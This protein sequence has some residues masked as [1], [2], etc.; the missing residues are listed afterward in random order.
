MKK[1][2]CKKSFSVDSY[3]ADGFLIPNNEK[4]V[5]EG[6]VYELDESERTII[7]GEVHLDNLAD[8]S[9]L[10]ITREHFDRSVW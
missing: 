7:G 2:K 3:D 4:I 8:G 10:E 6:E 1:Y 9:W 5:E